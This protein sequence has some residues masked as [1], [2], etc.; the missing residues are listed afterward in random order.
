VHIIHLV[1][2]VRLGYYLREEE[3]A[4]F[5]IHIATMTFYFLREG[6]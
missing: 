4:F 2:F 1:V 3:N 6:L 5:Y